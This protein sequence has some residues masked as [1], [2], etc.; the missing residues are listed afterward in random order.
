VHPRAQQQVAIGERTEAWDRGER[1]GLEN[2]AASVRLPGQQAGNQV[3]LWVAGDLAAQMTT[4]L[5]AH[6]GILP[7]VLLT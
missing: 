4:R 6:A 1:V 3:I 7:P 5:S 2:D